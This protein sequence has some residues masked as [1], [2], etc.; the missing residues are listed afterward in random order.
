[1]GAARAEYKRANYASAK[2]LY[3]KLQVLSPAVATSCAYIIQASSS[4][5]RATAARD[6]TRAEWKE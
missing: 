5:D 4:E 1:M 2:S 3:E 6:R